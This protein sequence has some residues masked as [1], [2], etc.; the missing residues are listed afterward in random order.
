[1]YHLLLIRLQQEHSFV[2]AIAN[3]V[4]QVAE[5]IIQI[6]DQVELGLISQSVN[7]ISRVLQK[8]YFNDT[9]IS[10]CFVLLSAGG[11]LVTLIL[12][13]GYFNLEW[14]RLCYIGFTRK[15]PDRNLGFDFLQYV[16]RLV[17]YLCNLLHTNIIK[18]FADFLT[19]RIILIGLK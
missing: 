2:S 3:F 7:G 19:F 15:K 6:S 12:G 16:Q 13:I 5:E 17:F 8:K 1:M 11:F 10:T 18:C 14:F 9:T 4:F